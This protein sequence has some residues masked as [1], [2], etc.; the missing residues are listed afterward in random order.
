MK[1]TIAVFGTGRMGFPLVERLLE[2][3]Y[4][5]TVYN[6]TMDKATLLEQEGAKISASPG[7]AAA[8]SQ[9]LIMIVS[10]A[11]VVHELLD[12]M[13]DQSLHSGKTLIV[14]STISSEESEVLQNRM[15]EVGSS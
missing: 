14:M 5:V 3:G 6:R 8:D 2:L 11:D 12:A 10:N 7:D 9:L 15:L 1:P 4:P 13:G